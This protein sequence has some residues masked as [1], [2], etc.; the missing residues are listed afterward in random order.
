MIDVEIVLQN[1]I[2]YMLNNF[3][4][5]KAKGIWYNRQVDYSTYLSLGD[6]TFTI[7]DDKKKNQK[8]FLA[9]FLFTF[10]TTSRGLKPF[11]DS[12]IGMLLVFDDLMLFISS[13]CDNN[14]DDKTQ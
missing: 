6:L 13:H 5:E 11:N 3:F 9:R 8:R 2:S 7:I 4:F 1:I 14:N 12:V 10:F